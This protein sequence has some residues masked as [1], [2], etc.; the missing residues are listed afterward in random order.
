MNTPVNFEIAK[1]LKAVKEIPSAIGSSIRVREAK[2]EILG[3]DFF[4]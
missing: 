2:E 3:N 4:L 1:L